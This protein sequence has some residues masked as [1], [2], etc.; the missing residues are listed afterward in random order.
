MR[1]VL[2]LLFLFGSL[3]SMTKATVPHAL[4]EN[5]GVHTAQYQDE[6]RQR[7][8]LVEI[9]Y[10]T[11]QTGPVDSPEDPVW[12]HPKEIRDVPI[13]EGKY[14]LIL[15]SHGHGGDRRDRSW[16]VNHLVKNGFIVASVEHYGNS[17]RNYNPV[18]TLHFW[19]RAKDITFTISELLKDPLLKK[20]IDPAKIG[21]IGYSLGGM[22][23]LILGGARA[24]NVKTCAIEF[25]KR[26]K[27]IDR[28]NLEMIEHTDFSEAQG[29]FTDARIKALALL[30]PAAF[31]ISAESFRKVKVPVALVASEEDEVLPHQEHALKIVEYLKPAK[32][33]LFRDKVSH[34]VF[35]NRVSDVGKSLLRPDIQ[36]ERIQTDR[37]K[38]HEEVGQFLAAFFKEHL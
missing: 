30:S 7:P 13:A 9:W 19:D 8:V 38:I 2:S 14:P 20:R 25:L 32:L 3:Q 16:L 22:T 36:T 27:E 17:W 23:G 21:F 18:L 35:L 31:A 34:Y 5:I 11:D 37:L 4:A 10:P 15:M 26:Y 33:K 12:E 29:N 6:K 28:I 1:W 24:Q